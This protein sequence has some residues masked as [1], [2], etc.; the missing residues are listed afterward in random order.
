VS[1]GVEASFGEKSP[2]K[3]GQFAA[4]VARAGTA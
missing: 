3:I 1:S 2:E 4:E